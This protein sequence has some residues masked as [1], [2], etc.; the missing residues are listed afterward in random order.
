MYIYANQLQRGRRQAYTR[1]YL[2]TAQPQQPLYGGDT[3]HILYLIWCRSFLREF[4][5]LF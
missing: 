5:F 1:S 2:Y 4:L 3:I